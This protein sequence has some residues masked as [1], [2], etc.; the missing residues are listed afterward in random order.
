[1]TGHSTYVPKSALAR[2][3]ESRLPLMGHDGDVDATAQR[4]CAMS[5]PLLPVPI[6]SA[7]CGP[8]SLAAG[9][10]AGVHHGALEGVEAGHLGQIGMPLTPVARRRGADSAARRAVAAAQ[11]HRPAPSFRRSGRPEFGA[12][13]EVEL[14][15]LDVGLEPAGELVLGMYAGQVGGKGM[16]GR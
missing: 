16:Y 8:S 14:Q 7:S 3:F 11:R 2:W 10:L 4:S 12:G 5:W 9:V 13:P 6:T 1:M 15:A